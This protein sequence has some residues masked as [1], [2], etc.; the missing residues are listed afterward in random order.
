[1]VNKCGQLRLTKEL[2]QQ[3]SKIERKGGCQ[4]GVSQLV[5]YC[6][7][8]ECNVL[9][10]RALSQSFDLVRR[11]RRKEHIILLV[12]PRIERCVVVVD[13]GISVPQKESVHYHLLAHAQNPSELGKSQGRKDT[14]EKA[15]NLEV[16]L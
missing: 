8:C 2:L 16:Q 10:T 11:R 3:P 15:V 1:M 12:D 9:R 6:K 7:I 13:G 4:S 14:M 5:S